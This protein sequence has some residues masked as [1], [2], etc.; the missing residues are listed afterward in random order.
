MHAQ[1][2]LT[3]HYDLRHGE[4]CT[5]KS[6]QRTE[7][8]QSLDHCSRE[9]HSPELGLSNINLSLCLK[10]NRNLMPSHGTCQGVIGKSQACVPRSI[11]RPPC[12]HTGVCQA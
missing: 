6:S 9:V 3:W 10:C 8:R 1:T 5:L 2:T 11:L 4:A 7:K 12:V